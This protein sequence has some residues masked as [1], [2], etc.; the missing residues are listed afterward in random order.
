MRLK[1]DLAVQPVLTAGTEAVE[2]L[3]RT[4][5]VRESERK[6]TGITVF[7]PR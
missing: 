6:S 3:D 4:N 5:P 7:L 1:P 2:G